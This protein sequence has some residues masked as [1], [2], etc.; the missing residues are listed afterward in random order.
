ML[1]FRVNSSFSLFQRRYTFGCPY[2]AE[3]V[4]DGHNMRG[5]VLLLQTV[6]FTLPHT[7]KTRPTDCLCLVLRLSPHKCRTAAHVR[8][9]Y[10]PSQDLLA[11]PLLS[12]TATLRLVGVRNVPRLVFA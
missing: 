2:T 10:L 12:G 8:F 6:S 11:R 7:N 3:Q 5:I 9:T 4:S 1:K